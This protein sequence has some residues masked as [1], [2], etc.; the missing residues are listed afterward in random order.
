VWTAPRGSSLNGSSLNV[1]T[2]DTE[3][4]ATIPR[5]LSKDLS[6]RAQALG[7]QSAGPAEIFEVT[8]QA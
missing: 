4:H 5:G 7:S 6:A 2:L 8:I 3:E 1:S